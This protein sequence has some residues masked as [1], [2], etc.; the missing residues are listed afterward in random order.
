MN[1][2]QHDTDS[3]QDAKIKKLL[4]HHGAVGY[5]VYFHCLELI[6]S[7]ISESN[8]TFEL[9]HDS[10]I[11]ASDLFIKGTADKS[12]IQIVEQI[13]RDIIDLGLFSQSDGHIFCFK[14]LKRMSLSMT[15]NPDFRAAISKKKEEY[16]DEIMTGH[17]S[18]TTYHER[19]EGLEGLE[20]LNKDNNMTKT[21]NLSKTKKTDSKEIEQARILATLLLSE[22]RKHDDKF[23][24]GK[25]NETISSW[26]V[27]I[28]KLIRIDQ[29]DYTTI[30][31]VI[32]WCKE[33]GNFW[34]P[35][36][37]SGKK[38]RDKFPTLISQMGSRATKKTIGNE[39]PKELREKGVFRIENGR[40]YTEYGTEFDPFKKNDDGLP[41]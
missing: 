37:L 40:Y 18:I 38:L 3:T 13:M 25:D 30:E 10:E 32:I 35:N 16:H 23:R 20:G 2:F 19:L 26:A 11:I 33:D 5:A 15:S 34:S 9:E 12:G 1:W 8:L 4:I 27:D 36:I 31:K 17:D 21:S 29:R 14:L 28:E 6:A 22:S 41:F 39:V 7:D 24:I